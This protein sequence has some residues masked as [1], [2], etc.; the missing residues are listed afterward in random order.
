MFGVSASKAKKQ[1]FEDEIKL[2]S[3]IFLKPL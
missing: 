2:F 3:N 1:A